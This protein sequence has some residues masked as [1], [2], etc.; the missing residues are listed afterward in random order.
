MSK[1]LFLTSHDFDYLQDLT[2]NG[3]VQVLGADNVCELPWNGAFHCSGRGY[4]RNLG[5]NP[6]SGIIKSYWRSLRADLA[7]FDAVVVGSAKPDCFEKY[8]TL[9]AQIPAATPVVFI[10][11]GDRP[12]PGGDLDRLNRPE[13][14]AQAQSVRPFARIFKREYLEGAD[15]GPGFTAFPFSFDFSRY[16]F[17]S[18]SDFKYQVSFWA[19][20]SDPVR[21]R[22]L[23]LIENRYDCRENGTIRNQIFRNYKRKGLFYLEELARCR[24]VL[25]FRGVGWDTL[26]FWE[27]PGVGRLLISQRPKIRIPEN[28]VHEKEVI[29]CKDDLSDLVDLIDYYLRNPSHALAI[30]KRGMEHAK[31]FHSTIARARQLLTAVCR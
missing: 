23:Q 8:L 13:L 29:Y 6:T 9:A 3:L 21:T 10:D 30:A 25:N 7:A 1:I 12:E 18:R 20:E 16:D 5:F 24:I 22:A 26:R 19:V 27:V 11:G 31:V 4:P 2:Y 14:Y 15:F 17:S 28:F